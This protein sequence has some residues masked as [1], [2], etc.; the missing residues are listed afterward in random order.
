METTTPDPYVILLSISIY[1]SIS[2]RTFLSII[3]SLAYMYTYTYIYINIHTSMEFSLWGAQE[4]L[5]SERG[6]GIE[7]EAPIPPIPPALA[8]QELPS[9]RHRSVSWNTDIDVGIDIGIDVNIHVDIG[10]YI[11]CVDLGSM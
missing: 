7:V 5:D 10:I 4:R 6:S 9:V 2:T 3:C 1:I 11:Y 8:P